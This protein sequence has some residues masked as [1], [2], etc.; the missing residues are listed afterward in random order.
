MA[1]DEEFPLL[2]AKAAGPPPSREARKRE[3]RRKAAL[4]PAVQTRSG[5]TVDQIMGEWIAWYTE[6]TG[7]PIPPSIRA[8]LGKQVKGLIQ[9]G[10]DTPAIKYGLAIWSV[11]Q[12]DYTELS[13]T[14]LDNY[15]FKFAQER[16]QQAQRWKDDMKKRIAAFGGSTRGST[17]KDERRTRTASAL[18][19]WRRSNGHQ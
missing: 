1:K 6:N 12:M 17:K 4:L 19:E 2:G 11:N 13:P 7:L 16:S 5:D 3:E 8:R 14:M 10:F 15:T 9:T 18:D